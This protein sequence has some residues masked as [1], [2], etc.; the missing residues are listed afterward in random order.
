MA[1]LVI[2]DTNAPVAAPS[3]GVR[4]QRRLRD[5]EERAPNASAPR[6]A[7]VAWRAA[8]FA[9]ASAYAH[10]K[11]RIALTSAGLVPRPGYHQYELFMQ[12]N[13]RMSREYAP[14]STFDGPTLVMRSDAPDDF[15]PGTDGPVTR[16]QH[17][18]ADLG[19]SEFVRGPITTVDVPAK[20]SSLLR[21]PAV[22]LVAAHIATAL[23]QP[24]PGA[25]G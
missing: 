12:L 4:A 2:L 24:E 6:A 5:L 17:A 22:D 10:A 7:V 20:H 3:L 25:S 16:A 18:F 19:W 8:T 1:R 9:V 23:G 21:K 15:P 14:S 11:R 13:V